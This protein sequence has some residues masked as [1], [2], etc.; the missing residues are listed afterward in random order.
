LRAEQPLENSLKGIV[1]M[2]FGLSL[3]LLGIARI[4]LVAKRW[5]HL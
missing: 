2:A 5:R 4:I 1:L 3:F